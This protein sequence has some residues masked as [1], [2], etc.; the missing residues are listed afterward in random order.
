MSVRNKREENKE[1]KKR[2]KK[3]TTITSLSSVLLPGMLNE[4]SFVRSSSITGALLEGD[5]LVAD[6]A[7]PRDSNCSPMKEKE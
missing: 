3:E 7:P 6:A 2:Q 5:T 1:D 4:K